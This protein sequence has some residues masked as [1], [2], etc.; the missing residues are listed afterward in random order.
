MVGFARSDLC[1][2]V[3]RV[4]SLPS[5][6]LRDALWPRGA[7]FETAVDAVVVIDQEFIAATMQHQ[8]NSYMM[9]DVS[10]QVY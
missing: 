8:K 1:V 3:V 2:S 4:A 7:F 6:F 5:C 10:H 9:T